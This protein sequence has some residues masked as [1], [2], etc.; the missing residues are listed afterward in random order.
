MAWYW[1][2]SAWRCYRR[3]QKAIKRYISSFLISNFRRVLN[4]LFF[5]L[6]DTPASEFCVPT[7][8]KTLSVL[9]SQVVPV[10][11]EMTEYFETS[12]HKIQTPG[13][14]PNERIQYTSSF[15][16]NNVFS[17]TQAIFVENIPLCFK[18]YNKMCVYSTV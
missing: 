16:L 4:V 5:H 10:K 2:G 17:T 8:R 14:H 7:F 12:A 11:V 13:S 18:F 3:P 15:M 6:G 1:S 9:S